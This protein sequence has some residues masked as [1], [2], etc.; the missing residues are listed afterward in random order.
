MM[1]MG[2]IAAGALLVLLAVMPASTAWS[3][4]AWKPDQR[5]EIIVG[6]SPGASSDVTARL[7]LRLFTE[8][9]L[10]GV[11]ATVANKPGGGGTIALAYLNQQERNGHHVMVTTPTLL[12][13]HITGRSRFNYTDV[14]PLAQLGSDFVVFSVRSESSLRTARDL[15][16]RIRADPGSLTFSVGNS[17]GSHGHRAAAQ[18]ARAVG[19]DPRRLKV[20]TFGGSAE[21]VMELLGGHIDVVASP[22]SVVLQHVK[23][24][25]ARFLAV[26]S[27][28]R[29]SG[30][31]A[32]VPTW[33]ELGIDAVAASWRSVIGPRDLSEAQVRYW[34]GV[35]GRL[36]ALPEW[37][38]ELEA[39]LVEPA[40]SNSRDTWMMME[41]EYRSLSGILSGL[42]LAR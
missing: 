9:R 8:K 16:D 26:A 24:G 25:R 27:D 39:R 23:A 2:M 15:A 4:S 22:P 13:N 42:G 38:E 41:R 1:P 31:L 19:A 29:L 34:D 17:I 5:I 30:E 37:R 20:V 18:V 36:A 7:M 32:S 11:M 6:V 14:T 3:A 28:R 33:K 40:Y 21:G 35:L 12:T 10:V